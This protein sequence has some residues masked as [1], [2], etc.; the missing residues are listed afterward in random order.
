MKS[1]RKSR[2]IN[3]Y[4]KPKTVKQDVPFPFKRV[5]IDWIDIITE[6]GWGSETEFKDGLRKLIYIDASFHAIGTSLQKWVVELCK[7]DVDRVWRL[8]DQVDTRIREAWEKYRD[9][10]LNG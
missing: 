10:F 5:R 2:R 9:G 4:T 8:A 3:S 6:G 1:K 7:D